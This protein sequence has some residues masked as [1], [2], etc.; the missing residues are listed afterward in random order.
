MKYALIEQPT[1]HDGASIIP[2]VMLTERW[3]LKEVKAG[4]QDRVLEGNDDV[5]TPIPAPS[6]SSSGRSFF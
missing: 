6:H 1:F 4:V 2:M 5:S 3:L